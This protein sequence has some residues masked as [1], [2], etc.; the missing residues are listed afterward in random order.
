MCGRGSVLECAGEGVCGRVREREGVGGGMGMDGY[1]AEGGQGEVW[2]MG[3]EIDCVFVVRWLGLG[4]EDDLV[5][6]VRM[7]GFWGC[8][9]LGFRG[10]YS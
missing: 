6:G 8:G 7:S 4:G 10:E 9:W 2:L 3:A 1:G 5:L